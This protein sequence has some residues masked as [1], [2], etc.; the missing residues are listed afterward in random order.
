MKMKLLW[1]T[2]PIL[3]LSAQTGIASSMSKG[4][5]T[6]LY[7]VSPLIVKKGVDSNYPSVAGDFLVFSTGDG[8][9]YRVERV[10]K[11][12][13][14]SAS[15]VMKTMVLNEAIRFGVAVN[16]GSVGY[17]SNRTGPIASW[18]WLGNGE[19]HAAIAHM[20]GF[21]GNAAP[22]HLNASQ[23]GKVWCFDTSLQ[24]L[25]QNTMLSEFIKNTNFELSGQAWRTYD[26]DNF[27]YKQGYNNTE[28][29]KKNKF[30]APVL[31][32]FN[33]VT[34]QLNM[35]PNAFNGTLSS[36]G[37]HVIFVRETNGNYD[38]WMQTINGEELVQLTDS[39][40]ADLE[41]Q[42]NPDGNKVLFVSN[43]AYG[44]AVTKTSLYMMDLKSYKITRLT[45]AKGATDGGP[46]WLDDHT[47]VFHSNRSLKKPQSNVGSSWNIW[48][49]KLK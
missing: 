33:R 30:D 20:G 8:S 21:S 29:G 44:G 4:V 13:P 14:A 28:T 22:F 18:M 32:V 31:Y 10:S 45:N 48:Q 2:L 24:K 42:F 37:K 39:K 7:S 9:E 34:S 15:R 3:M 12:S 26:S 1:A 16:D 49:L 38:L 35:I 23:D 11:H 17:V 19:S 43:R 41:P 5:Q 36:D 25:R 46:A 47:V 40:Y 6:P 27:R